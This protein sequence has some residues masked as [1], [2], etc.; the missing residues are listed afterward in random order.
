MRYAF[1]RTTETGDKLVGQDNGASRLKGRGFELLN[2]KECTSQWGV[3][4]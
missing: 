2:S 1:N 3:N 4:H